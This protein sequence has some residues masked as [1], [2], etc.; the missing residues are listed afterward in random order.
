MPYHITAYTNVSYAKIDTSEAFN[1]HRMY[2]SLLE[3]FTKGNLLE[4]LKSNDSIQIVAKDTQTLEDVLKKT[5]PKYVID[6]RK[7]L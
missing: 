6:H 2:L 7:D 1:I 3:E 5:F 4:V